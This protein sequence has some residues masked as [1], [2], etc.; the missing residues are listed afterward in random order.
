MN[1][2]SNDVWIIKQWYQ[3]VLALAIYDQEINVN[4]Q[5]CEPRG[6]MMLF[7]GASGLN[8]SE[9]A[10]ISMSLMTPVFQPGVDITAFPFSL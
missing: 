7:Q 5:F 6:A 3:V 8:M 1:K 9:R 10:N 4:N 2:G